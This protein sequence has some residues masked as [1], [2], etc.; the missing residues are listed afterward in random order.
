MLGGGRSTFSK[1]F[2]SRSSSSGGGG[3]TSVGNTTTTAAPA[4]INTP[5]L[6]KENRGQ[7]ITVSL[8]PSGG[9][10]W[11]GAGGIKREDSPSLV[12]QEPPPAH[13]MNP[14][15]DS[16]LWAAPSSTSSAF[17]SSAFEKPKPAES[18]SSGLFG[19]GS[20]KLWGDEEVEDDERRLLETIHVHQDPLLN[21]ENI[22]LSNL[23]LNRIEH[24]NRPSGVMNSRNDDDDAS[25][26]NHPDR[27]YSQM[28][29]PQQHSSSSSSS[30]QRWRKHEESRQPPL[31]VEPSSASLS[32]RS[33]M[34]SPF[35]PPDDDPRHHHR[36]P[37]YHSHPYNNSSHHQHPKQEHRWG[38]YYPHSSSNVSGENTLVNGS[39]PTMLQSRPGPKMLFDHKTGEMVVAPN[40]PIV[41]PNP[42]KKDHKNLHSAASSGPSPSSTRLENKAP[43]TTKGQDPESIESPVRVLHREKLSKKKANDF[44][45]TSEKKM[46]AKTNSRRPRENSKHERNDRESKKNFVPQKEASNHATTLQ[47]GESIE[48]ES[49][50]ER[51][52]K[53][54]MKKNKPKSKRL[55]KDIAKEEVSSLEMTTREEEKKE[56]T[57]KKRYVFHVNAYNSIRT[58]TYTLSLLAVRIKK[59]MLSLYPSIQ[60]SRVR[61]KMLSKNMS[62]SRNQT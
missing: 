45:S 38:H 53:K 54:T 35:G 56:W 43:S 28:M 60:P 3:N 27:Q 7:D 6:R 17:F 52:N 11:G 34:T 23:N 39:T 16:T 19:L 48:L 37:A 21:A 12:H 10:G 51:E 32:W 44:S 26:S 24:M 50:H 55:K 57:K 59:M 33:S 42:K 61:R 58:N 25:H 9:S 49:C 14:P 40:K 41:Q 20:G 18:R 4:P 22:D 8:V 13:S 15:N 47:Q 62:R 5:S 46:N 2:H 30:Q 1:T 36:R 31:P 29:H